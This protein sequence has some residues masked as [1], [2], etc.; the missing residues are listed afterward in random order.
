MDL[1]SKQSGKISYFGGA[2]DK[3][4]KYDTPCSLY[5]KLKH[6]RIDTNDYYCAIRY[7]FLIKR[8]YKLKDIRDMKVEISANG[9]SVTAHVITWGPAAWTGRIVDA[10]PAIMRTLGVKTDDRVE[11][12][13]Y[14]GKE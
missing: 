12:Q 8:G 10:S 7:T 11:I 13:I 1:L 6:G 9:K 2:K 14:K 3:G 4:M 5:P